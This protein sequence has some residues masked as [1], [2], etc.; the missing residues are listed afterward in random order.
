MSRYPI[1]WPPHSSSAYTRTYYARGKLSQTTSTNALVTS[2]FV[3]ALRNVLHTTHH[4]IIRTPYTMPR[5]M[6]LTNIRTPYTM[7]R[8]TLHTAAAFTRLFTLLF[9]ALLTAFFCTFT[10]S[11]S[12]FAYAPCQ[13][14]LN[15]ISEYDLRPR[16]DL[17]FDD[18]GWTND[19]IPQ[20]FTIGEISTAFAK[21]QAFGL[22]DYIPHV[23]KKNMYETLTEEDLKHGIAP[24]MKIDK[25]NMTVQTYELSLQHPDKE[26]RNGAQVSALIYYGYIGTYRGIPIRA[27]LYVGG[28]YQQVWKQLNKP[29]IQVASKFIGGIAL[30]NVKNVRVSYEIDPVMTDNEGYYMLEYG[31]RSF[32]TISS[33]AY[34]QSYSP[35]YSVNT[36]NLPFNK[37]PSD[38]A[39]LHHSVRKV[40]YMNNAG[41]NSTEI[42][43]SEWDQPTRNETFQTRCKVLYPSSETGSDDP[44]DPGF[45]K[46]SYTAYCSSEYLGTVFPYIEWVNLSSAHIGRQ[47]T[48][49]P[50]IKSSKSA[51]IQTLDQIEFD[52]EQKVDSLGFTTFNRFNEMELKFEIPR[53][54][55]CQSIEMLQGV[56]GF[57]APLDKKAGTLVHN[58][59]TNTITFTFN[60]EWLQKTMPL[61]GEKYIIHVKGRVISPS[62]K[63]S[64][65]KENKAEN[66]Y[67]ALELKA[68]CK[69]YGDPVTSTKTLTRAPN[70]KKSIPIETLEPAQYHEAIPVPK[71]NHGALVGVSISANPQAGSYIQPKERVTYTLEVTNNAL[72][73]QNCTITMP[74]PKHMHYIETLQTGNPQ[75]QQTR[76]GS[77]LEWNLKNLEP[78]SHTKLNF[79]AEADAD[80]AVYGSKLFTQASYSFA[81]VVVEGNAKPKPQAQTRSANSTLASEESA[82]ARGVRGAET[83]GVR[84]AETRGARGAETHSTTTT[85]AAGVMPA[86]SAPNNASAVYYSNPLVHTTKQNDQTAPCIDVTLTSNKKAGSALQADEEITYTVQVK[87]L[88]NA[89]TQKEK[90]H[91][92]VV[93]PLGTRL[94]NAEI[95]NSHNN[96]AGTQKAFYDAVNH[97]IQWDISE[98]SPGQTLSLSYK[99]RTLRYPTSAPI[100]QQALFTVHNALHNTNEIQYSNA[101]LHNAMSGSFLQNGVAAGTQTDTTIAG[102]MKAPGVSAGTQTDVPTPGVAAGTQTDTSTGVSIETQT[103]T[104][105]SSGVETGTQTNTSPGISTETQTDAP[106]GT[107]NTS[108]S[109]TKPN[110]STPSGTTTPTGTH[111]TGNGELGAG[112]DTNSQGSQSHGNTPSNKH[113]QTPSGTTSHNNDNGRTGNDTSSTSGN[114]TGNDN[115]STSGTGNG[116][117]STSGTGNGSSTEQDASN[118]SSTG[119]GAD[120]DNGS[121]N[122]SG[123][124]A[125]SSTGTNGAQGSTNDTSST[126]GG[127]HNQGTTSQNDQNHPST[128]VPEMPDTIPN[129]SKLLYPL[130]PENRWYVDFKAAAKLLSSY[131]DLRPETLAHVWHSLHNGTND[132]SHPDQ[133]NDTDTPGNQTGQNTPHPT[134]EQVLKHLAHASEKDIF[135]N[136]FPQHTK[137]TPSGSKHPSAAGTETDHASDTS[138]QSA[139][140]TTFGTSTGTGV[141]TDAGTDTTGSEAGLGTSTGTGKTDTGTNSGTSAGTGAGTGASAGTGTNSGTGASTGTG[142]GT[143]SGNTTNKNS[144]SSQDNAGVSENAGITAGT[145]A[146]GAN[147]TGT[148]ALQ[149]Q[150]NASTSTNTQ[151][152]NA[153]GSTTSTN[154]S[155][156]SVL[157]TNTSSNT[158]AANQSNNAGSTNGRANGNASNTGSAANPGSNG[159][160]SNASNTNSLPKLALSTG[161]SLVEESDIDNEQRTDGIKQHTPRLRTTHNEK[162]KK[163]KGSNHD[164]GT[165][166]AKN[167]L[168]HKLFPQTGSSVIPF[169]LL[170]VTLLLSGAFCFIYAARNTLQERYGYGYSQQEKEMTIPRA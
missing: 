51:Q 124:G 163:I 122:V 4:A 77:T 126:H 147:G 152:G 49:K 118:G 142:A 70:D 129:A 159:T 35:S 132:Q 78:G 90:S 17:Q 2:I 130:A 133:P 141:G 134:V 74:L 40:E 41:F 168:K 80:C 92:Y 18:G 52:L 12:A 149:S 137:Q 26:W 57:N 104:H 94:D 155:D 119:N 67:K 143:T 121:G 69:T 14:Q 33:L 45:K 151:N 96:T 34:R 10:F 46:R 29:Y 31:D 72:T 100:N 9:I 89:R 139:T 54:V 19:V 101:L 125:N 87:D 38:M 20:V 73:S 88:M 61:R 22:S 53:E 166:L 145:A 117:G 83:R 116:N 58:K 5:S 64:V 144:G 97:C 109:G 162:S 81:P 102:E 131:L 164:N 30:F 62:K 99:A 140:G 91:V 25:Q 28:E 107:T 150:N 161:N 44:R 1:S 6:R 84:G 157:H 128:S 146:L 24:T 50:L 47:A 71:A 148:S 158:A 127:S 85:T 105:T 15:T 123:N 112:E 82:Q 27:K 156:S 39:I 16:S 23:N 75:V 43:R 86:Q 136:L 169:I 56:R 42:D 120:S 3:A 108:G 103:D 138:N 114:S 95:I 79:V 63:S 153:N 65:R 154:A 13:T 111:H 167:L 59:E 37:V 113:E 165:K 135:S 106:S 170:S 68:S 98:L 8:S 66:P 115:S 32:V 60:K 160:A 55:Q 21:E 48:V 93:V 36:I 11:S 76:K 7:P 110:T